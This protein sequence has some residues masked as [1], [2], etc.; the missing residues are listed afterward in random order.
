[1]ASEKCTNLME[2]FTSDT[3]STGELTEEVHS[4]SKTDLITMDSSKITRLRHPKDLDN[5]GHST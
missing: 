2:A 5:I 1:M 4:F 3:S